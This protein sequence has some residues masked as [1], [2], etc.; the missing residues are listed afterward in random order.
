M[1]SDKQT[2]P[3]SAANT[4]LISS[5]AAQFATLA[6][7]VVGC[8]YLSWRTLHTLNPAAPYLS[9]PFLIADYMGF[10]FFL[11]FATSLWRYTRREPSA[12]IPDGSVDVFITTYNEDLE[13][14]YP[15]VTAAVMMDHPHTTYVL[16]DG[17]RP[18]VR[19]LCEQLGARYLTREDN[20]GAKAGNINAALPQTSGEFIAFLDADHVPFR[21]FLTDLMCHF[22]DP[23]VA[24]VQAPQ[25]YYN[26]DSFQH[27]K[28]NARRQTPW[29]EQSVFYERIMPGKDRWNAAFWC[30][31][32]AIVRRSALEGVGGVDTRT[33][34]EDM[35]TT[36][37]LH[38]A[39]WRT[40]YQDRAVAVGVA[41]DDAAAFLTQRL[42]WAQGAVQIFR[43]DNPFLRRGLTWRQRL[44]YFSSVAYVFEYI[45][46]ATYLIVPLIALTSGI[47]PMTNMGWN[48]VFRFIPYWTLGVVATE[49]LTGGTNPYVES[50]RFHLLKMW[51]ALKATTTA[52]WPRKLRFQVTPKSGDGVD[53]RFANLQL[54]RWQL[55]AGVASLVASVWALGSWYFGAAWHLPGLVLVMTAGWALVNAGMSASLARTIVRRHHRRQVYRFAVDDRAVVGTG[56]VVAPARVTDL[57]AIGAGWQS[58]L[59]LAPGDEA[60]L[61]F[62]GGMLAGMETQV[63]VA[64]KHRLDGAVPT[65]HYGG[66]FSALTSGDQARLILALFQQQAPSVFRAGKPEAELL[67]PPDEQA[68]LLA[69]SA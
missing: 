67:A 22:S 62:E 41:P 63:K 4:K 52:V 16:D 42:R 24:L 58:A 45:P 21:H 49:L 66:E 37:S 9:I 39:G 56:S 1:P 27:T 47:L 6:Y 20:G 31:S 28:R 13:L 64:S 25:A 68:D 69:Q 33:V 7:V 17:R 10:A 19:A 23:T 50:E 5:R 44:S 38:A 57:S 51:I 29:H 34:T 2:Q 54:I 26:L 43:L 8:W 48:L 3:P 61:R 14:L 40:V 36:M 59:E 53:H 55:G 18:E 30:G 32:S 12:E 11:L 15:T 46:K 65:F 60:T 35:H